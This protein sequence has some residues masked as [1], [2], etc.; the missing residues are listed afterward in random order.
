MGKRI[1]CSNWVDEM[2]LQVFL[3]LAFGV[4][5]FLMLI[6]K[7]HLVLDAMLH[8]LLGATMMVG[9]GSII[10]ELRHPHNFLLSALRSFTLCMQGIWMITVQTC[11]AL[12][13]RAH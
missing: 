13:S 3:A 4:E 1:I 8:G 10:L 7:K 2:I 12:C 6:H 5:G 9:A 11:T